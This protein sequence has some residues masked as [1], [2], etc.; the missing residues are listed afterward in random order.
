M[1]FLADLKWCQ[2]RRPCFRSRKHHRR[3]LALTSRLAGSILHVP[4]WLSLISQ[5]RRYQW[6][7]QLFVPVC[8]HSVS[9]S[10]LRAILNR[11]LSGFAHVLL[12]TSISGSI[13]EYIHESI[14]SRSRR[15]ILELFWMIL[16]GDGSAHWM[17]WMTHSRSLVWQQMICVR[18]LALRVCST[19]QIVVLSTS[20]VQ[21]R[22]SK[23]DIMPFLQL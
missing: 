22:L 12:T 16:S 17:A 7:S 14:F 20:S 13:V 18:G 5:H 8:I 23:I 1:T 4:V 9:Q 2:H 19:A 11:L 10:D 3:I 6:K 15:H 21:L